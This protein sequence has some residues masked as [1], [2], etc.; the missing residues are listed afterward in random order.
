MTRFFTISQ[1]IVITLIF[2]SAGTTAPR[3]H[4]CYVMSHT[5]ILIL[6]PTRR[7]ER[8]ATG[9][10]GIG[11]RIKVELAEIIALTIIYGSPPG[12]GTLAGR[13][14]L[15]YQITTIH[16]TAINGPAAAVINHLAAVSGSTGFG[17]TA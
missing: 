17:L 11:G 8:R 9:F 5:P 10:W 3:T 14:L 15:V 6:R 13:M 16:L 12:G 1:I 2:F 4:V 7:T